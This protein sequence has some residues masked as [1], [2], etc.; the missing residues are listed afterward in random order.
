MAK[1]RVHI[2]IS[3]AVQ[4]VYYRQHTAAMARELCVN[5]WVRNLIDGRVEAVFE[6]ESEAVDELVRWCRKGPEY[7]FVQN[8]EVNEERYT[9]V[10]N[11]FS[12]R[13]TH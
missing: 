4:G 9:G 3:G 12:V 11:D 13:Y 10:F 2:F 5:G 7:A 6:G 1:K 8:V